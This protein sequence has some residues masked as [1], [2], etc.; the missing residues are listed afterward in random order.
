MSALYNIVLI[1]YICCEH[2]STKQ[3]GCRFCHNEILYDKVVRPII[4]NMWELFDKI[5]HSASSSRVI[6]ACIIYFYK[7]FSVMFHES[8]DIKHFR[9]IYSKIQK[10][11]KSTENQRI[12]HF[13]KCFIDAGKKNSTYSEFRKCVPGF[14]DPEFV[15][16]E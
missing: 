1:G 16:E 7:F 9:K 14:L 11:S 6:E 10:L 3:F 15:K 8:E 2:V 5:I 4:N 13:S 12:A